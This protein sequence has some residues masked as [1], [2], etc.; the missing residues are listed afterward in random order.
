VIKSITI[1][2]LFSCAI[3]ELQA[4]DLIQPDTVVVRSEELVLKGLLWHPPGKGPFPGIIY[5]HGNYGDTEKINDLVVGPIFAKHGYAFLFLFRRG[6]GL[7]RGQGTNIADIMDNAFQEK[8][9]HERNKVQLQKLETDQLQDV[10]AGLAFLKGRKEVDNSHIAV[11]GVSLGTSL[12]LLLA[13]GHP[14]LKAAILFS[15]NGN[16]WDRSP[17][18]RMRLMRAAK[19][20][21]A[22]IMI[23]QAANDYSLNPARMLDSVMNKN[24]KPHLIKIYPSFGNS[25]TEG[26]HLIFLS[27]QTW[28]ADVFTFLSKNL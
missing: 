13:E 8:G 27:T 19:N 1:A 24:N 21:S 14:E 20:I 28:E 9:Q 7:S 22:P 4:Q 12:A 10:S 26:H 2:V 15:P 25:Q 17:E 23:T 5:C 11:V 6:I 16:S 18:L 3:R